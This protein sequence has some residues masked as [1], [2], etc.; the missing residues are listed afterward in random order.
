MNTHKRFH[1]QVFITRSEVIAAMAECLVR[2]SPYDYP[3][4]LADCLKE[5]AK[6]LSSS[7]RWTLHDRMMYVE[8]FS[9]RESTNFF[10]TLIHQCP[11]I[12]ALNDRK[13]GRDGDCFVDRFS[14]SPDPDDD[15]IGLEALA[16]NMTCYF[17]EK[18]DSQAYL[19]AKLA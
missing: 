13:N 4:N 18:A 19:D 7:L 11:S 3:H 8:K 1:R 10:S 15:F 12:V 17:A 16:Q 9:L 2:L 6:V 5:F 14:R